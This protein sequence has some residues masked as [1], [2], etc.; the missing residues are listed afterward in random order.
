VRRPPRVLHVGIINSIHL[1]RFLAQLDGLGWEQH[2]V[3]SVAGID[4]HPGLR[5]VRLHHASRPRRS[6]ALRSQVDRAARE[7]LRR[8]PNVARALRL[9]PFVARPAPAPAPGAAARLA[10]LVREL[11]PDLVFSHEL[12]HAGYLT[13]EAR[14]LLPAFPRWAVSCWGSDLYLYRRLPEHRAKLE[15]LLSAADLLRCDCERDVGLARG[16][17]FRGR[18][19]PVGPV[20]AYDVEAA[21]AHRSPGPP[22]ARRTILLKGYQHWAGRALVGLRAL[23]R[24]P[25]LLAGR[26]LVVLSAHPDVALAARLLA[27]DTGV[28]LWLPP[29]LPDEA[30][31]RLYGEARVSV[32]LG[33][34]DG[35]PQTFLEALLL[36]AFPV[37]SFTSA[38]GEWVEDGVTGLLVPP[39]DPRWS[40]RRY[41]GR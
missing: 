8:L 18:L 17:G 9:T 14:A 2:L 22:S 16:L 39:E 5:G 35:V 15:A 6:S 38:A 28:E 25:E 33:I 7:A 26:R 11:S 36:G 27:A 34:S 1:V 31:P 19:L 3:T 30:L 37:Q 13:L 40:P 12:Q 21:Q 29:Y 23:A 32:G 24:I 20:A 10:D 4:P 41:T